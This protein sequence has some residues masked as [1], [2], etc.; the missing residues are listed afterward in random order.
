MS[1]DPPGTTISELQSL[2]EAGAVEH[3]ISAGPHHLLI[4]NNGRSMVMGEAEARIFIEGATV[5]GAFLMPLL[6]TRRPRRAP[7]P[8]LAPEWRS[9]P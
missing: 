6:R 9:K 2:V 8:P 3:Y 4:L 5:M 7:A 1:D